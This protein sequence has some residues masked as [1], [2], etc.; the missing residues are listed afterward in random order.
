[1]LSGFEGWPSG[2]LHLTLGVFDAVH[3]GHQRLIATLARGAHAA[4]ATALAA[5][6]DPLP[7]QVLAPGAPPSALSDVDERAALLR[8]AGAE[9][10]V[11]FHFDGAL[12]ALPAEDFARALAG[13]GDVRRVVVGPDFRFGHE[14]K[15]DAATL[16]AHRIEVESVPALELDGAVVSSTRV[17][18][19]LIA[20]DIA[21]A[22]RLLGRDYAVRGTVVS[23]ERRGRGLGYPTINIATPPER[24]LP[25]DGIY[26][27]WVDVA[28]ARHQAAA[29]LGV[30]PTFGGGA[31][32]LEAYLLDVDADLY[33]RPVRAAF[34][35][36]LRDEA[37]FESP[38]DLARQ[39]ARDVE[40][41]RA[42]LR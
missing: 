19:A 10:V 15:G 42:A 41:T 34:V 11:V 36:R 33:D 22:R 12:A 6:F 7:K 21:L 29:S 25:K 5:T 24:L 40:A 31:R 13:A 3:R 26:A 18:N 1:M 8:E 20:G 35:E 30:R 17:R 39:I 23:G 27:M 38:E 9:H 28:G 2:P 4:G 37:F 32:R 16:R 14:R